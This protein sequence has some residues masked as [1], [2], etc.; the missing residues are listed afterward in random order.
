MLIS[1]QVVPLVFFLYLVERGF[2][3][4]EVVAILKR[5]LALA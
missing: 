3:P 5:V 4:E 2:Y 1:F